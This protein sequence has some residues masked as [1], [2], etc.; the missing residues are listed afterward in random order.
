MSVWIDLTNA[1]HVH[2]FIQLIR[3]LER[4]GIDYFITYRMSKHLKELINLY[5]IPAIC[6]GK[7]GKDIKDKLIQYANRV[8]KLS[9]I[10]SKINPKVAVAK[11]SVE[12]P[13]VA[14][15]L[16]IKTIFVVDNEYAEAQNRLTLPLVDK[17]IKPIPTNKWLLE[18]YGGREFLEFDGVCEMANVNARLKNIDHNILKRLN[19]SNDK[20]IIIMRPCP[21]SSY[22][23]EKD[24]LPEIIKEIKKRFDCYIIAFPRTKKQ[25]IL[26]KKLNTIV[27]KTLDNISL[28]Y[29]SNAMIGAGGTMNRESAIIGITTVSC[30]PKELLGV[31][32][33]LI[34]KGRM[35]H[36]FDIS[37]IIDYLENNLDKRKKVLKLEDPTEMIFKEICKV[38]E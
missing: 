35:I 1:P 23:N 22:C 30:Y 25:E 24:I 18:K 34:E 20:P 5:N 37:E 27:P 10:I 9:K 13:R 4:E 21:N 33:Y 12:L 36:T 31:D 16:N 3:K 32:K 28:L 6:V 14:F 26:Y 2:F 7:H 17:I 8:K 15:G 19:I 29:H 38:I 11:H